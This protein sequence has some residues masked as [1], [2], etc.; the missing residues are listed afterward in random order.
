MKSKIV[1]MVL[2]L[3]LFGGIVAAAPAMEPLPLPPLPSA[4][5]P[6]PTGH[7]VVLTWVA[8]TSAAA[9]VAPNCTFAY[10]VF[11]GTAAGA[12]SSTP[13]NSTPLTALTYTDAITLTSSIQSYFYYVEAVETASGITSPSVP[14][15]E[16]SATFPGVPAAPV[17]SITSN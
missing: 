13:L 11:K 10:N 7:A 15:N 3:L 5:L 9:C 14:S 17:V 12:E 4:M 1:V 6:P 2:A 8:S 16:V